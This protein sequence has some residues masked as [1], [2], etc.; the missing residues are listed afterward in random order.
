MKAL[1]V[2][3]V[4][5]LALAAPLA[6]QP[7][8]NGTPVRAVPSGVGDG[9][10]VTGKLVLNQGSGCTMVVF[11]HPLP[12]GY[13]MVAL[14]AVK[15]LERQEKGGWVGVPVAPLLAKESKECREAAND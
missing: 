1:I 14:N 11:D 3:S 8:P 6:A 5:G 12:G 9:K 10:P 2:A 7:L 15:V 13:T 4:A